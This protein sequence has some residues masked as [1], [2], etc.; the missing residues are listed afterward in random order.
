LQVNSK[1]TNLVPAAIKKF[2]P[3]G[4]LFY[5]C[6][7]VKTA[8]SLSARVAP[9]Q[10]LAT[11]VITNYRCKMSGNGHCLKNFLLSN[12]NIHLHLPRI[13]FPAPPAAGKD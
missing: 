10:S 3:P 9:F 6:T 7:K 1:H 12:I 11:L 5:C 8:E 13:W 2:T 4:E